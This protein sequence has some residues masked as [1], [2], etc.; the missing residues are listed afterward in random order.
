MD[1]LSIIVTALVGAQLAIIAWVAK[2]FDERLSQLET[3]FDE[4]MSKMELVIDRGERHEAAIAR[5]Q[6]QHVDLAME[7]ARARGAH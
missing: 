2:K 7:L 4:R 1:I 5:L 3:R 6:E